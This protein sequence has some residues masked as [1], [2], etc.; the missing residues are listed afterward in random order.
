[1]PG[2]YGRYICPSTPAELVFVSS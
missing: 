2:G 1:M